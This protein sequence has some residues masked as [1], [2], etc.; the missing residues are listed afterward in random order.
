MTEPR[1][2]LQQ[3]VLLGRDLLVLVEVLQH[4]TGADAEVRATRHDPVRRRLEH[5]DRLALVEVAIPAGLLY[6]D[7]FTRQ[8]ARDE[9]GFP[10]QATDAAA[11]MQQVG[12]FQFEFAIDLGTGTGHGIAIMKRAADCLKSAAPGVGDAGAA[13]GSA[14][15][16]F[17]APPASWYHQPLCALAIHC[18]AKVSRICVSHSGCPLATEISR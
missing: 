15:F 5:F 1:Q 10:V 2:V 4:A 13:C 3:H 18:L 16:C 12:D 7:Q 11:V 14:Y 6:A 9:H 8:G 17:Q